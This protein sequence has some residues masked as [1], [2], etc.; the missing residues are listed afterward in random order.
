MKNLLFMATLLVCAGLLANNPA[1]TIKKKQ[2]V[3]VF[4]KTAGFRHA[5]IEDGVEAIK[6]LGEQNSYEVEQS[7]DASV[8]SDNYLRKVDLVIFL[9]TTEDIL[10][11]EQEAA[12]KRY[13]E[14][15]K[16][17]M[18]IHAAT[19]TEF[20]WAWYGKLI[21]A[22]FEN[23]PKVQQARL[24]VV[25]REH[26]SCKHLGEFWVRTDEWYNFK[27]INPDIKVL[28]NLDETSYEGGTNGKS[29]PI[30]WYHVYNG[31]RVF[32]TGGGHTSESYREKDFLKH[33]S[34]GINWCLGKENSIE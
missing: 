31:S 21:G 1:V 11:E 18:G 24:E 23:H 15:G 6:M 9:S 17:F 2:K 3:L 8:F 5:S 4:T 20:E 34:G 33:L 10:N 30:A 7:E 25:N 28:I 12:F 19:D 26:P 13:I 22:Y 16:S 29:H 32:Y 14:S 27:T